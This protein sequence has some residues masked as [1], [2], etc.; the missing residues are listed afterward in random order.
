VITLSTGCS[1]RG[2][3]ERMID[4]P[5]KTIQ[6]AW[7]ARMLVDGQ[8]SPLQLPLVNTGGQTAASATS[9]EKDRVYVRSTRGLHEV[10]KRSTRGLHE[11]YTRSTRGLHEVYTRST[12]GLHEVYTRSTRGLHEVYTRS[13]R[14]LHEVYMRS[15]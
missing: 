7:R 2:L 4:C 3:H 5:L 1:T 14:G 12:R 11:V 8:L 6:V 10:Y 15:T 9:S 13:T